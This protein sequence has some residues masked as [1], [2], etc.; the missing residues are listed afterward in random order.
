M[1]SLLRSY[2]DPATLQQPAEV[3]VVIATILRP[4]LVQ[5][6]DSIFAQAFPGRIQILIGV[7]LPAIPADLSDRL[8][9]ACANRPAHVVVQALHP[10]YSTSARHGGVTAS[11][12]GGALRCVLSLL[13]NSRHVAY[14]DDDNWFHPDHLRTLRDAA[15]R[16]SW[17]WS[18]RWFVHPDTS[19]PICIDTWES[20]G[21][22]QGIFSDRFGGFVDTNCLMLDKR[23]CERALLGWNTPM[24]SNIR[25]AGEDRL[26]FDILRRQSNLG[27][28]QAT[29]YY[30]M[31]PSDGLH[32]LRLHKMG[33]RY[34]A[35]GQ[36]AP[37]M[38][39]PAD[40]GPA[41]PYFP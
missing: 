25:G 17:G 33:A 30:R 6:V 35:A 10:G 9:A 41:A 19:R 31:G 34:E 2:G 20:V 26:V 5:A 12:F 1:T 32:P 16:A 38:K 40:P 24:H 3:A 13:A 11:Y 18:L 23:H 21:P 27:T 22:G 39:P 7:D 8:D 28:G 15:L 29:S 37:A 14:L 4:T 36:L